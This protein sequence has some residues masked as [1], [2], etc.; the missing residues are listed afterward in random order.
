[1]TWESIT[2]LSKSSERTLGYGLS[3]SSWHLEDLLVTVLSGL[4]NLQMRTFSLKN[5]SKLC[6]RQRYEIDMSIRNVTANKDTS[7]QGSAMK[8]NRV[9]PIRGGA[10]ITPNADRNQTPFTSAPR[11]VFQVPPQGSDYHPQTNLPPLGGIQNNY[12]VRY[13]LSEL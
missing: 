8:D 6:F 11:Q 13:W 1:M 5:Y 4:R 9:S 10:P 3:Q 12:M 2:T 7:E